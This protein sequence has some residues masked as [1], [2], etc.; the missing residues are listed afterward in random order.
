MAHGETFYM[1]LVDDRL[2]PRRRRRRIVSP[3]ERRIDD[4]A[5]GHS[6]RAVLFVAR[7]IL[8]GMTDGV[9]EQR[10]APLNRAGDRLGV[11]IQK[12]LGRIE[13]MT[14]A[15]LVRP[16]HPI[17]V[18]LP[19]PCFGQVEM[20][21]LVRLLG[22]RDRA[23]PAAL[24]ARVEKT[25]LDLCR[26]LGEQRKINPRAIPSRAEGIRFA[27]PDFHGVFLSLALLLRTSCGQRT[28][29]NRK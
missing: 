12:Q 6:R 13:S 5:L 4:H 24:A 15:G 10:V 16:V 19:R 2:V 17:T 28:I 27:R 22:H 11:G 21:N 8:I 18:K 25:K 9:A 7:K 26:V 23:S 3:A 1:Q 29:E 20:P 14:F